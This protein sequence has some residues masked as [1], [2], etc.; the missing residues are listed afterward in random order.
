[1]NFLMGEYIL[2]VYVVAYFLCYFAFLLTNLP[3]KGTMGTKQMKRLWFEGQLMLML[4]PMF[5]GGIAYGLAFGFGAREGSANYLFFV[6]SSWFLSTMVYKTIRKKSTETPGQK[7]FSTAV[8]KYH[9]V[10]GPVLFT[11]F[12]YGIWIYH[13]AV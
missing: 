2:E 6:F 4:L 1:M 11:F 10:I 9:S 8:E 5:V 3:P 7:F 12:L 13:P